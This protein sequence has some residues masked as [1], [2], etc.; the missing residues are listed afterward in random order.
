MRLWSMHIWIN[1]G[2]TLYNVDS[3]PLSEYAANVCGSKYRGSNVPGAKGVGADNCRKGR[4]AGD[5]KVILKPNI[6][7]EYCQHGHRCLEAIQKQN[8]IFKICFKTTF[9]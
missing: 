8:W 4:G 7:G 6:L 2:G 3:I 9:P 5:Q 1:D